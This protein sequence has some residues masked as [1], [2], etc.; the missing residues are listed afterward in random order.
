MSDDIS[1]RTIAT[2]KRRLN[3]SGSNLSAGDPNVPNPL[4]PSG[5]GGVPSPASSSPF[6]NIPQ[7]APS[8]LAFTSGA[9]PSFESKP[10]PPMTAPIFGGN[11]TPSTP[12]AS[13]FGGFNVPSTE[14]TMISSFGS[15]TSTPPSTS[16]TGTSPFSFANNST[17]SASTF[18]FNTPAAPSA[19]TPF[20][21]K[22][23]KPLFG[24]EKAGTE[25]DKKEN[26][27]LFDNNDKK[28]EKGILLQMEK[29]RDD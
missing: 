19:S 9:A 14:K 20:S 25:S 13:P 16:A 17:S 23:N 6:N 5:M 26:M 8:T 10:A 18:N 1:K 22:S 29:V 28:D 15:N 27:P 11:T 24:T 12:G 4:A 3:R 21:V 7:L 2:P